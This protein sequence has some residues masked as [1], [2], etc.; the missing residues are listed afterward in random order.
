MAVC[1]TWDA[2]TSDQ[3]EGPPLGGR[4]RTEW[5]TDRLSSADTARGNSHHQSAPWWAA[6]KTT[7]MAAVT[8]SASRQLVAAV[9]LLV[10][11]HGFDGG[12]GT[13]PT[14]AMVQVSP[15]TV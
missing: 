7:V 12:H 3:R 1:A 10:G 9:G 6:T 5:V 15:V 8:P 11:H 4:E 13:G 2:G 14:P